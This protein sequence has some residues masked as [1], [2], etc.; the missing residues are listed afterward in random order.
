MAVVV[1][2]GAP[3]REDAAA[4]AGVLVSAGAE[5]VLLF[6]SV[7]RGTADEYSDIDL[8]A[9]FADLDYAQRH[10]RKRE[11]EEVAAAAVPRRVQVHVTDRPEWRARVANVAAS[12]ECRIA[13]DAVVVGRSERSA[14][15]DWA[16]EMVLPMSDPQEALRQFEDWVLPQL[17]A[18]DVAATAT[19]RE[20]DPDVPASWREIGRLNRVVRLCA[21]AALTAETTLKTLAVLYGVPTPGIKQ[22]KRAGHVIAAALDLVPPAPRAEA[23][24]VFKRH[25]IDLV[26]LSRWREH[27]TY[28]DDAPATRAEADTLAAP[29]AA[30]ATDLTRLA[31]AHLRLH[32]DLLGDPALTQADAHCNLLCDGI[33]ERDVRLGV[34]PATPP[35]ATPEGDLDI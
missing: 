31:A 13:A 2:T 25:G 32:A 15:V 5:E 21:A 4:V 33:A 1:P 17:E 24:A 30:M 6:G 19:R 35:T 7:A 9:I 16:K 28:P 26:A 12:F 29:Y 18:V 27:G 23:E 20:R 11:L 34:T 14:P 10:R 8:V 22:L 3:T